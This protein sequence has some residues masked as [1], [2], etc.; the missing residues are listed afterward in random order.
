MKKELADNFM[1]KEEL[2]IID[3]GELE[4]EIPSAYDAVTIGLSYWTMFGFIVL[5]LLIIF[6]M[7]L[8]GWSQALNGVGITFV[9]I[10]GITALVAILGVC[11]SSVW[12]T[13]VGGA[14]V[15]I[16]IGNFMTI[17]LWPG[18]ILFVLGIGLIVGRV[19]LKKYIAKKQQCE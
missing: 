16:V 4:D 1:S 7:Y 6:L 14:Y 15:G 12:E 10:S 2:V 5:S 18:L 3:M 8:N 19:L 11:L 9:T 13:L 17:N